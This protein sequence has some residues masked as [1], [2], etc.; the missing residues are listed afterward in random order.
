MMANGRRPD[1]AS[2]ANFGVTRMR[3][4]AYRMVDQGPIYQIAGVEKGTLGVQLKLEATIQKSPP[5]TKT[6]T[7]CRRPV[8]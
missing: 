5:W 6:G 8:P 1:T 3:A 2:G 7:N 4:L